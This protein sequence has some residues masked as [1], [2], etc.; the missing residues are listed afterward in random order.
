MCCMCVHA[1]TECMKTH[2][3]KTR[4]EQIKMLRYKAEF[5]TKRL[6]QIIKYSS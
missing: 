2:K 3:R 1:H 4:T 5:E 6:K